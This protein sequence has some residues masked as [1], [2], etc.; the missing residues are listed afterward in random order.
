MHRSAQVRRRADLVARNPRRRNAS[1]DTRDMLRPYGLLLADQGRSNGQI[2]S[3]LFI[4]PK[5]VDHHI[6]ALLD[7]L[8]V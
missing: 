2:A 1:E 7:K 6:S 8:D 3:A 4:S 5:T